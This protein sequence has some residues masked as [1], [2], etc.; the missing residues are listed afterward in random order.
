DDTVGTLTTLHQ[1]QHRI[2]RAPW[3]ERARDLKALR[4]QAEVW[5]QIGAEDGRASHIRTDAIGSR[6][7]LSGMLVEKSAHAAA[8]SFSVTCFGFRAR[9]L[10]RTMPVRITTMPMMMGRVATSPKRIT[11]HITAVTGTRSVPPVACTGPSDFMM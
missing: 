11:P 9:P 10:V 2:E 8:G 1:R 3:L 5:A 4:L 7:N 6:A